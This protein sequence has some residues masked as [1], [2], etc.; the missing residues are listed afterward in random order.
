M[1]GSVNHFVS[2]AIIPYDQ[3][4]SEKINWHPVFVNTL[5]FGTNYSLKNFNHLRNFETT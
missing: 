4:S 2:F 5:Y 3:K 1:K